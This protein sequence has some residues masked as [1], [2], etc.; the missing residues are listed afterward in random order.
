METFNKSDLCD[1]TKTLQS[2]MDELWVINK[3]ENDR[4]ETDEKNDHLQKE[5]STDNDSKLKEI[6]G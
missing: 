2:I 6:F 4:I 1:V 5:S 3:S